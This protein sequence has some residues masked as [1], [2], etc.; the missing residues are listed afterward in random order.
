MPFTVEI[1]KINLLIV[2]Y[3]NKGEMDMKKT[4]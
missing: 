2:L 1:L 4:I 3:Q